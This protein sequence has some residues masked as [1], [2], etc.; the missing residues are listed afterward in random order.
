MSRKEDRMAIKLE[1]WEEHECLG[2][3][4]TTCTRLVHI[5]GDTWEYET[6]WDARATGMKGQRIQKEGGCDDSQLYIR[7][8]LSK[9]KRKRKLLQPKQKMKPYSRSFRLAG[10]WLLIEFWGLS[11]L[12][13]TLLMIAER[14]CFSE[15]ITVTREKTKRISACSCYSYT[16]QD[17]PIPHPDSTPFLWQTLACYL[18]NLGMSLNFFCLYWIVCEVE[19][20]VI[21][22]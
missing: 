1:G 5:K 7:K 3:H 22:L 2:G 16:A 18:F 17:Q 12:L 6:R 15:Q 10:N 8:K 11:S 21:V 19:R 13:G 9:G 4:T 14:S 20:I